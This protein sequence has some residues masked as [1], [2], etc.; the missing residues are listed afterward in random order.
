MKIIITIRLTKNYYDNI[1]FA[2]VIYLLIIIFFKNRIVRKKLIDIYKII[3]I[4]C[5]KSFN[6]II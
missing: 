1:N 3:Y 5:R 4:K 6:K 2:I